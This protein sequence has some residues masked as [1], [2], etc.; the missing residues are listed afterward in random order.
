MVAVIVGLAAALLGADAV[1][2]AIRIFSFK[3]SYKPV[4]KGHGFSRAARVA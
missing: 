1:T 3:P 4:L 2:V